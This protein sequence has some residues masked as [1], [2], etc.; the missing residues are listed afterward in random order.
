MF[1][2]PFSELPFSC[3]WQVRDSSGWESGKNI[4]PKQTNG[5]FGI[6]DRAVIDRSMANNFAAVSGT[7]GKASP[8]KYVH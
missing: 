5:S 7:Q 2:F 8:A 6:M 1:C 4:M 3:W